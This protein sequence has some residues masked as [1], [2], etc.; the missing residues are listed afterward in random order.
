MAED[1]K[2]LEETPDAVPEKPDEMK[3]TAKEQ[4]RYKELILDMDEI[5]R[6]LAGMELQKVN[7]I[8]RLQSLVLEQQRFN[9]KL[10]KRLGIQDGQFNIDIEKGIVVP[11]GSM[12]MRRMG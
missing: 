12:M 4:E 6:A 11:A 2:Q 7:L 3:L 8:Q 9:E 10:A 5:S 1:E